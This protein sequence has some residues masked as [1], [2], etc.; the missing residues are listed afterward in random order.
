MAATT[1]AAEPDGHEH[2]L[3]WR[4]GRALAGFAPFAAVSAVHLATKFVD[5]SPLDA[6]TKG[7][8]IPSLAVGI[9]GMLLSTRRKPRVV[10]TALLF[11]GLALSWLGDVTLNISLA[12][13]LGF[14]LAA[15]LTYIS[16]F[17][18]AF[19]D[20]RPSRWSVLAIPWFTALVVLVGPVL[21]RMLIPV[22]LYSAI[23]GLMAVWA[24]RGTTLTTVGAVLFVVSDTVLAF[25]T[26]TPRLQT[27]IWR[28]VVMATY[29]AAQ[30]LISLGILGAA[31]RDDGQSLLIRTSGKP[32]SWSRVSWPSAANPQL[33]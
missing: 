32:V 20:R 33:S 1:H 3:G 13:G 23:L 7:L 30:L 22:V 25:R 6:V 11:I 21:G 28:P 18:F 29:L 4:I 2:S 27:N 31:E 26:F 19:P 12:V 10:V 14:F 15:H 8:E 24:S 16:M 17:Q 5:G 9:G